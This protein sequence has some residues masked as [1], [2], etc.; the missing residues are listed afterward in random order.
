MTY[1]EAVARARMAYGQIKT[2]GG[3]DANGNYVK[4]ELDMT[5]ERRKKSE[6][7]H[8]SPK[9]IPNTTP[10]EKAERAM[11]VNEASLNNPTGVTNQSFPGGIE[12]AYAALATD[13]RNNALAGTG[14][15][16]LAG[17][18]VGAGA[19]GRMGLFPSLRKRRLLRALIALGAGGAAGTAAGIAT[20][21]GLNNGKIQG[22]YADYSGRLGNALNALKGA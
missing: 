22:A 12:D 16:A 1:N 14:I 6:I 9:T 3:Y 20:A 10:A 15:G 17:L 13:R 18:G 21:R 4:S 5:D 8:G 11:A 19:Y 7:E 2:A